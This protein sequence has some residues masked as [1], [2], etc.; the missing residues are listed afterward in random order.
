[1]EAPGVEPGSEKAQHK[2]STCVVDVLIPI[3]TPIDR[4]PYRVS[5]LFLAAF[6]VRR[7]VGCQLAK[8]GALGSQRASLLWTGY[9]FLRS[10]CI[11]FVSN[12][13]FAT[14]FNEVRNRPGMQ[15]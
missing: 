8:V 9:V 6:R 13:R 14:L 12:Y 2:A 4:L 5:D 10:H 1:M 15:L 7:S 11:T 3:G